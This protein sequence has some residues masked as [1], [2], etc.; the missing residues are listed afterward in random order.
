MYIKH[1][2]VLEAELPTD[3]S[4]ISDD[5]KKFLKL[6]AKVPESKRKPS[7]TII[8]TVTISENAETPVYRIGTRS[9][10]ASRTMINS[11][12]V[13]ARTNS[14]SGPVQSTEEDLP[15]IQQIEAVISDV[16]VSIAG[17]VVAIMEA[18]PASPFETSTSTVATST[19]IAD[20]ARMTGTSTEPASTL[21]PLPTSATTMPT[22]TS[23]TPTTSRTSAPSSTT[24]ISSTAMPTSTTTTSSTNM[25][26]STEA[27]STT[28]TVVATS[29]TS[30]PTTSIATESTSTTVSTIAYGSTAMPTSAT[31]TIT[32]QTQAAAM[33]AAPST[34]NIS[35]VR[36]GILPVL[37][38]P[39]LPPPR[40]RTPPPPPSPFSVNQKIGTTE[41][42]K[43]AGA[44]D[45]TLASSFRG[46]EQQEEDK[47]I[48]EGTAH[49]IDTTSQAPNLSELQELENRLAIQRA[50]AEKLAK[51]IK[52]IGVVMLNLAEP[53]PGSEKRYAIFWPAYVEMML[54]ENR[55]TVK[56]LSSTAS[57]KTNNL[58]DDVFDQV[59]GR[60][61]IGPGAHLKQGEISQRIDEMTSKFKIE[62]ELAT[63]AYGLI[64]LVLAEPAGTARWTDWGP[65]SRCS[66][67]CGRRGKKKRRRLCVATEAKTCFGPSSELE[68]CD[69]VI[70]CPL[71]GGSSQSSRGSHRLLESGATFKVW[72]VA[73]RERWCMPPGPS[74]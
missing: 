51:Q 27:Q 41:E 50:E 67:T 22:S 12:E 42:W 15:D 44:F 53:K 74:R 7:A 8:P 24:A 3:A 36:P 61:P 11:G 16:R 9:K 62:K 29:T 10:F 4:V 64:F 68:P 20:T 31:I 37:V 13:I 17:E 48:G 55:L 70:A 49:T 72:S 19:S 39:P 56:S 5:A 18:E 2:G 54:G 28:I 65:W 73:C 33:V 6:A 1:L 57:N 35:A 32:E 66:E 23:T 47:I 60:W 71:A 46:H 30:T 34:Q 40:R 25:L 43:N 45:S 52:D 14:Q 26:T 59:Q 63:S 21:T 69:K 58:L 38:I